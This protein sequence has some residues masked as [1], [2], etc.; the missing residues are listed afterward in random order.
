[1]T[2]RY[3]ILSFLLLASL[4][5]KGQTMEE[6]FR[7][8]PAGAKPI[9]IWQWMDGLVTKEGIT[10]DLEDYKEAGIGGVQ[11][12]Q[13]GGPMQTLIKDTTNAIG[14]DK[15]QRLMRFAIDECRRLGLSFGTHNCPGWSSSAYPTVR[16]EYAMQQLVWSKTVASGRKRTYLVLP[17][18]DYCCPLKLF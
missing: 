1:M 6:A 7:N 5:A 14:S 12:F 8:P 2:I 9:M 18:T 11:N 3:L 17:K 15:W 4:G 10:A 16:P 13:V